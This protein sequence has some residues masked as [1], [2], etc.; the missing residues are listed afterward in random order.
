MMLE[1]FLERHLEALMKELHFK[2]VAL[3]RY[4]VVHE[5]RAMGWNCS[6]SGRDLA[7]GNKQYISQCNGF[8]ISC[9]SRKFQCNCSW[10]PDSKDLKDSILWQVTSKVSISYLKSTNKP[11]LY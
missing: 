4:G 2:G 3:N 8:T 6:W 7:D 10:L 11:F 5:M 1:W 9:T